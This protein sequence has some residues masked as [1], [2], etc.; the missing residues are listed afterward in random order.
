[1]QIEAAAKV[2]RREEDLDKLQKHLL[3]GLVTCLVFFE[4]GDLS[5]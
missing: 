4:Q 5:L 2:P 3:R 1:M